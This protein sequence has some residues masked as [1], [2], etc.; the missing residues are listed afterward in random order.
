MFKTS[1]R[2]YS[3]TDACLQTVSRVISSSTARSLTRYINTLAIFI[4]V[5]FIFSKETT[6]ERIAHPAVKKTPKES[7]Y[8]VDE[9][10]YYQFPKVDKSFGGINL[11]H[12]EYYS[13]KE[14]R[15]LILQSV[16]SPKLKKRLGRYIKHTMELCEKYQLD[17]FWALSVMWTESHFNLRAKSPVSATG[18]MQIM[19]GTGVYLS[20]LLKMP[21]EETIVYKNIK[22]PYMNIEMGVFY[23]KRLLKMFKGSYRL[24]T[25]AYNMG[26]GGVYRRLRKNLPV[27]VKNLYLDKVRKHYKLISRNF[28]NIRSKHHVVLKKTLV[29]NNPKTT[30]LYTRLKEVDKVFHFVEFPSFDNRLALNSIGHS[31]KSL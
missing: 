26:P 24:A 17:P 25:A 27:G 6:L 10:T 13:K 7:A 15:S 3:I 9:K 11:D 20:K 16:K 14:V 21:V 4:I 12:M 2:E 5:G 28:S 29:I 18:L 1:N 30:Y 22:D 19:P 8:F 23:L 31:Q